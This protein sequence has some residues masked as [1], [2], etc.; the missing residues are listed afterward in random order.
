MPPD[1][2][3]KTPVV[4]PV[5]RS[6]KVLGSSIG[7][8]SMSKSGFTVRRM[9]STASAITVSV[10]SPRKSI[11]RSPSFPTAFMSYCT[12]TSPSWSVSGTNSSSGRSVMMIPA[13]CLPVF[14]TMP[15][16]TFAWSTI[17]AA[18]GFLATSSL[19]S[20]DLAIACSSVMLMSSGIIFARRSA[21]A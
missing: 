9:L 11:F 16:R 8:F 14:L 1:S 6:A 5:L 4:L 17:L 2:S 21:S 18:T 19:S 3:W 20:A 13:A 15:S 12:V 10:F 7:T